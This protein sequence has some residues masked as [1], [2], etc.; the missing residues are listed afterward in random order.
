MDLFLIATPRHLS[1]VAKLEL[2]MSLF[3]KRDGRRQT[4]WGGITTYFGK[5]IWYANITPDID[6]V[7]VIEDAKMIVDACVNQDCVGLGVE[8]IRKR[9]GS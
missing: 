9:I 7:A 4:P 3:P 5:Q 6:D 1:N 2:E 8:P